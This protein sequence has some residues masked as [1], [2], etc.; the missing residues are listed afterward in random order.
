MKTTKYYELTVLF[1][2]SVTTSDILKFE[3]MITM[4]APITHIYDDGIK[5]LAYPIR[6]H[7]SAYYM[8]FQLI[9][10]TDELREELVEEI[11][12]TQE[13][14]KAIRFL[15]VRCDMNHNK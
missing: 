7:N 11:Y 2:E 1:D 12:N 14:Y 13:E 9:N 5:R 3:N 10:I 6:E 15:L 8:T 4:Y